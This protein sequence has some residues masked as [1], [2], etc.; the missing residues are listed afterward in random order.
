MPAFM[1]CLVT[2][3]IARPLAATLPHNEE[4]APGKALPHSEETAPGKTLLEIGTHR[5]L[6][7]L[8]ANMTVKD[9][10]ES[11]PSMPV[12]LKAFVAK[13]LGGVAEDNA[14]A[15]LQARTS[16]AKM[17]TKVASLSQLNL[18]SMN[19]DT[20]KVVLNTLA[21]DTMKKLDV[22]RADCMT[23]QAKQQQLL[24]ETSQDM[25]G[26][27]AQGTSARANV[28]QTQTSIKRLQDAI[29]K[30]NDE[31]SLNEAKCKES[32]STLKAQIARVQ[33]DHATLTELSGAATCAG[34]FLQT[35]LLRCHNRPEHGAQKKSFITF[36]HHKLRRKAAQLKSPKTRRA[37]QTALTEAYMQMGSTR[38]HRRQHGHQSRHSRSHHRHHRRHHGHHAH[39]HR[40]HERR[41]HRH[42]RKHRHKHL[43]LLGKQ[44]RTSSVS[45]DSPKIAR[46]ALRTS[47]DCNSLKDKLML[48]QAD[49]IDDADARNAAL[50][51][52]EED[53]KVTRDNLQDQ[54]K[55]ATLRLQEQQEMLA[56]ATTVVIDAAEQSRLKGIQLDHLQA[57][58]QKMNA[59]CQETLSQAAGQMCKIKSIRQELYKMEQK[60]PFIQDCEVSAWTPAGECSK[61]CGSGGIVNL[62]R[63]VVVPNNADGATCPPLSMQQPC[64]Q[65]ECPE[66]CH[67]GEWSG[68]TSCSAKCGGG[69][70]QRIRHVSQR[71]KHGGKLC[72]AETESVGCGMAACDQDCT[73][74]TWSGWSN[75]SKACGGGFQER[76]RSV[77]VPS[78]GLGAC[79]AEDSEDRLQYKRCNPEKC[80]PKNAPY[81]K[82]AAKVDVVVLLD[83]S[84]SLGEAG[85]ATMKNATSN[86]VKALDPNANDGNGAQVAVLLY[87]GPTDMDT[88]KK[89]TGMAAAPA[90][91][92][93]ECKMVWISHFTTSNEAVAENINNV[94]WQKGSTMTSQ[95][96]ASAEAELVYG[97]AD[98]TQV[99]IAFADRLPM[100]PKRTGQ[101]AASL[102]KKARLIWAVS[103]GQADVQKF[104]SW[105]S[106]PAA[107]NVVYVNGLEELAKPAA[108]NNIIADA[109]SKVE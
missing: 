24:G 101:A 54:I 108:L 47:P 97:R 46:C 14:Q 82:C 107:D 109:C 16:T 27:N 40:R 56:E 53:C 73:L 1:M 74:E 42:G 15:F 106:R 51:S 13:Q 33:K 29:S 5:H 39:H 57:E 10:L 62:V 80:E 59:F 83:S 72:G 38:H 26:F 90:D 96:L 6:Q 86:L 28:M 98:A 4:T 79:A 103:A 20:A 100:M 19:A 67:M 25:S 18:A 12:E 31:L 48:M 34:F 78:T 11:P 7:A 35:G 99:V 8:M 92:A 84:G 61:L 41:H 3:L 105:A 76:V 17:L 71:A 93:T 77:V 43:V 91:L 64:N 95:A 85:W 52:T 58:H 49:A 63:Q 44:A 9:A 21:L 94:Y 104:A 70:K 50:A 60:R 32:K 65:Q 36:R 81:L 37:L 2:F 75:C 66:D 102:R 45:T 22:Q 55:S 30:L 69:I 68:W 88:Y 87:S 23:Q 89:C